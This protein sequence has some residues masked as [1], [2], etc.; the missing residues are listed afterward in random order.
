MK[1]GYFRMLLALIGTGGFSAANLLVSFLLI[2]LET[3]SNY[4]YYAFF[5]IIIGY[6]YSL[7]NALIG[8][9][10]MYFYNK[11][12][13]SKVRMIKSYFLSNFILSIV[14]FCISCPTLV[15][16][17]FDIFTS[18]SVSLYFSIASYRWFL[19]SYNNTIHKFNSAAYSDIAYSFLVLGLT[20]IYILMDE[21]SFV[22]L[23]NIQTLSIVTS[24]VFLLKSNETF[25]LY[26]KQRTSIRFFIK[27]FIIK[28]RHSLVGVS[29][30]EIISNFHVYLIMAL[31]GAEFFAVVA[32]ATLLY[33]P[34]TL[35]INTFTQIDRPF[36]SKNY[37]DR[38]YFRVKARIFRTLFIGISFWLLSTVLAIG[39]V[40]FASDIFFNGKFSDNDL[41]LCVALLAFSFFAKILKFPISCFAQSLGDFKIIANIHLIAAFVTVVTTIAIFNCFDYLYILV[42]VGFGEVIALG[43]LFRYILKSEGFNRVFVNGKR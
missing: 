23:I 16:F 30:S 38:K 2:T 12:N 15:G 20:L 32:A 24:L 42:G 35:Y 14:V 13:L 7:S 10:L 8:S 4:G 28:G 18:L 21:L 33:R 1:S 19:R 40:S 31:M 37:F 11:T 26:G 6:L 27:G 41:F 43:L 25:R 22:I 39:L 29:T 9:P 36:I 17:G 34:V 5:Q 3:K